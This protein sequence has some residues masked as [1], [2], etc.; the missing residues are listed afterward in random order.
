MI[1]PSSVVTRSIPAYHVAVGSPA[2]PIRKV[3]VGVPDA[4]G[5]RYE[6]RGDL[7][8]VVRTIFD[9]RPV[10]QD[11]SEDT[12]SAF[13]QAAEAEKQLVQVLDEMKSATSRRVV[14]DVVVFIVAVVGS[15]LIIHALLY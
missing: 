9:K 6:Q 12:T 1:G 5:L 4:P 10:S 3:S 7:S 15:W 11:M 14:V 2:R 8:V 13:D